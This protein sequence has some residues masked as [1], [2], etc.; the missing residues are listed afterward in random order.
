[1]E[2]ALGSSSVA[3]YLPSLRGGGAERVMLT[4]ASEFSRLG[5]RTSLV[6]AKAE[7]PLLSL[8]PPDVAVVNLG[9]RRVLRSLPRLVRYLRV[10]RP[11]GMVSAM[12]HANVTA[13]WAKRIAGVGTRMIVTERN[14]LSRTSRSS[15]KARQ[16]MM[17]W[18]ARRFYPW[19]DEIV[20]VSRGVADDLAEVAGVPK[21][22]IRVIYNPLVSDSLPKQSEQPV[23]HPWFE[24]EEAPVI[25]G[26]GRLTAQKDFSTLIN[27]FATVARTHR[28]NLMILGEGPDRESLQGLVANL[29]LSGRVTLPGYVENP[30][31]YMR[32]AAVVV[33]SSAW[34][35]FPAVLVEAMACG[36]PVVST[37]CPSGPSEILNKG[38]YG[39]LV[40]VGDVDALAAG[41]QLAL[42]G[43]PDAD[44]LRRRARSFGVQESVESYLS[45]LPAWIRASPHTRH[46]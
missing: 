31:S 23:D 12:T 5:V 38:E 3:F 27:A 6:L 21:D 42:E 34:E 25:L 9:R 19:A 4:L 37:D 16:G 15:P 1:M 45:L 40:P 10:E 36:T 35:G 39:Q 30:S 7:G 18:F 26:V 41:I 46:R 28:A 17:P 11:V 8:V 20:A 14:T 24:T 22:R 32:R 44:R 33:L 2:S 43:E 29:G 13:L